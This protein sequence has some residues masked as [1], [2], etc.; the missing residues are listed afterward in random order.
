MKRNSKLSK[1]NAQSEVISSV[2]LI[3]LVIVATMIIFGFVV[4]FVKDKLNSGNCLDVTG[5]IEISSGY[6][7]YNNTG[8]MQV[9]I[10]VLEISNLIEGVSIELGGA[11]TNNYKIKNGTTITGVRMCNQPEGSL[12]LPP[13]DNTE[14]TY[15][16]A[17][18]NAPNVIRVYPILKGGKICDASDTATV[19]EGCSLFQKC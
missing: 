9:Q 10:H 15:V 11:S 4:P 5:K 19:I 2:L 18:A 14:R 1:S 17:A 16:I 13:N 6:T 8:G 7:C 3:L 12:E